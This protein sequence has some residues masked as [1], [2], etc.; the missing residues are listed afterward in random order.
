MSDTP[1]FTVVMPTYNSEKTIEKS[2]ASIAQQNFDLS[3]V[4]VLVIDGGSTDKTREITKKYGATVLENPKRLPE[5]AKLIGFN[6][7]KGEFVV[8]MD[9]DE[10]FCHINILKNR[11]ELIKKENL[12]CLIANEMIPVSK[13]FAAKYLNYCGDPFSWF[14]Y[15]FKK[16]QK[17]TYSNNISKN[18]KDILVFKDGDIYPIGDGGTTTVSLKYAKEHFTEK[19]DQS[20]FASSI[21]TDIIL[22]EKCCGCIEDD[23]VNHYV[24]AG[25]KTYLSKL[26]FR[27]INN[28]FHPQDSGFSTREGANSALK[29]RKIL[30]MLYAL[31][32]VFPLI[33]SVKL[34]VEYK[35]IKMAAHIFYL[36]Y[37]CVYIAY[38]LALK[39]LGK[40]KIN[41]NYGK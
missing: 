29:K 11:Y 17:E 4:E 13:G 2:L 25:F 5:Y 8:K 14:V 26:R 9:S 38:C 19:F 24:N 16:T 27:V 34:A 18:N 30:F 41:E 15:Q 12:N 21:F 32:V 20:S 10:E 33:D 28:L 22:K 36:Y 6:A 7:A 39:V 31:S 35:D 37:V 3:L 1:F 23:K 40:S